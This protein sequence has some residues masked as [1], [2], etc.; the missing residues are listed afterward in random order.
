MAQ[1]VWRLAVDLR[2]N[3]ACHVSYSLREAKSSRTTIVRGR[4]VDN[5]RLVQTGSTV[6][7]D[8]NHKTGKIL[9]RGRLDTEENGVPNDGEDVENEEYRPAK[10]PFVANQGCCKERYAAEQIHWDAEVLGLEAAIAE[11]VL[12]NRREEATEAVKDN[13]LEKLYQRT[14]IMISMLIQGK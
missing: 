1:P 12:E 11:S 3:H 14:V 9:N 6:E 13:V 8:R 2:S 4:V 5:P 10:S 7:R